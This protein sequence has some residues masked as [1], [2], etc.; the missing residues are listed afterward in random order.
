MG[1]PKP[2]AGFLRCYKYPTVSHGPKVS[3]LAVLEVDEE[4]DHPV[5]RDL[6]NEIRTNMCP[7]ILPQMS[8]YSRTLTG[9]GL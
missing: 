8:P 1:Q 4:L 9:E 3:W 7:L 6:S 2:R 5:W